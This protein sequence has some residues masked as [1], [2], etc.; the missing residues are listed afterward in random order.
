VYLHDK[1]QQSYKAGLA[2]SSLLS[3]LPSLST[4]SLTSFLPQRPTTITFEHF[5]ILF[6]TLAS[7]SSTAWN[8]H[9]FS[10]RKDMD[11]L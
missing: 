4:P 7:L 2:L 11:T 8:K 10:G 1:S 6:P 9:C 5:S 3:L